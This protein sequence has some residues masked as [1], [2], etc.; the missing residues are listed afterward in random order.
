MNDE[1]QVLEIE[2]VKRFLAMTDDLMKSIMR[3]DEIVDKVAFCENLYNRFR[4]NI[5][6]K[7]RD[8]GVTDAETWMPRWSYAGTIPP[9]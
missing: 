2:E 3:C 9:K 8:L 6:A 7:L 1:T 5:I 4:E